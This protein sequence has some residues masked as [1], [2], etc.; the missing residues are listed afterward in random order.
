[1]RSRGH[2][3]PTCLDRVPLLGVVGS[4]FVMRKKFFDGGDR[5]E[6]SGGIQERPTKNRWEGSG[7]SATPI[8][9]ALLLLLV[10]F[11]A[12]AAALLAAFS[13]FDWRHRW[14]W[15]PLAR[16]GCAEESLPLRLTW[17]DGSPPT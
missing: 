17:P 12:F 3:R 1:M 4:V 10:T 7:A 2:I 14:P 9:V 6:D 16:R 13:N 8:V 11:V 15:W 5:I